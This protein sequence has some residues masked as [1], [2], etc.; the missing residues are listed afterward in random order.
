M[1]L[2]KT[3]LGNI[4]DPEW[5]ERLSAAESDLL[6]IDQWEAAKR[7]ASRAAWSNAIISTSRPA[8]TASW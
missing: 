6:E 2:I 3:V 8:S 4:G 7:A 1:I 5:A